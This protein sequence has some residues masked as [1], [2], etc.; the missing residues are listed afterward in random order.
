MSLSTPTTLG[1]AVVEVVVL[2]RHSHELA[3]EQVGGSR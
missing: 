2:D 3:A 1:L